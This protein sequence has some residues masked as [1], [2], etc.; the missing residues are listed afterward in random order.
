[1][2]IEITDKSLDLALIKASGHLGVTRNN[3]AYEI[4]KEKKKFWGLFGSSVVIKAWIKNPKKDQLEKLKP[5]SRRRRRPSESS[6]ESF[7]KLSSDLLEGIRVYCE[8]LCSLMLQGETVTVSAKQE[9]K[10]CFFTCDHEYI[11]ERLA[12]NPKIAESIEL[13]L[14]VAFKEKI[15]GK[16]VRLFFDSKGVRNHKKEELMALARKLSNKASKSKKTIAL[17]YRHAYDRKII[18]TTLDSD[19]RVY[20]KSVGTGPGRKLLIIPVKKEYDRRLSQHR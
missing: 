15:S 8:K 7:E 9:G 14:L 6:E 11:A 20:T 1:M 3:L 17:N 2:S 16:S 10:T 13:V 5:F 4:I 12:K 19:S 18:H